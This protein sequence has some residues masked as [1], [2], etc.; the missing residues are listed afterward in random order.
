M[1]R[2]VR[3]DGKDRRPWALQ[4]R[5]N[6]LRAAIAEIA[7]RGYENARLVDIAQRAE[8]TVGSIYT[9]F[10]DKRELFTAALKFS[11]QERQE[12]NEVLLKK[13]RDSGKLS[14]N[15]LEWLLSIAALNPFDSQSSSP[16]ETQKLLLEALRVSWRNEDMRAEVEPLITSL[17]DQ[18]LEVVETAKASGEIDGSID[19]EILARILMAM[20]IGLI[21]MNL[22]ALPSPE[23]ERYIPFFVALGKMTTRPFTD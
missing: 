1:P 2:V 21:S 22:A 8:L 16:S 4:S 15:S 13:L 14:Q 23:Q 18:Y 10:A 19:S 6:L 11:I 3:I 20:P 7:E 12:A 9:W 17:F 5:E